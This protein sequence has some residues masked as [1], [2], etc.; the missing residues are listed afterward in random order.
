MADGRQLF[1]GLYKRT[2]MH[3]D[4]VTIAYIVFVGHFVSVVPID[5]VSRYQSHS[6][7]ISKPTIHICNELREKWIV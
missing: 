5:V 2:Y 3:I 4:A 7:F 6:L 1:L